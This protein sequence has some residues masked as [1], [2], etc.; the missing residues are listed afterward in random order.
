MAYLSYL[1]CCIATVFQ[2]FPWKNLPK[3]I[4]FDAVLGLVNF[5]TFINVLCQLKGHGD[6]TTTSGTFCRLMSYAPV[7]I[8][9]VFASDAPLFVTSPPPHAHLPH[10]TRHDVCVTQGRNSS[11]APRDVYLAVT[12]S[13]ARQNTKECLPPAPR[14]PPARVKNTAPICR[15]DCHPPPRLLPHFLRERVFAE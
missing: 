11:N 13:G 4:S 6:M 10:T 12:A 3:M 14:P 15:A 7:R 9:F 1:I 5:V 8:A 2:C